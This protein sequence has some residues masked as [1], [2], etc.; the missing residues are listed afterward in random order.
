M[1]KTSYIFATLNVNICFVY[2]I[3]SVNFL[4]KEASVCSLYKTNTKKWCDL[5]L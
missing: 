2:A 1:S 3:G 5:L 4:T